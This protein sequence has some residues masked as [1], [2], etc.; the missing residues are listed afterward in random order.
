MRFDIYEYTAQGGRDYNE[1]AVGHIT[2]GGHGIFAVADGLGGHSLGEVASACARDTLLE[3]WNADEKDRE[4]W[5]SKII[6][7]AN[8]N[9]LAIQREK[10]KILKSTLVALAIDGEEAVWAHVGDSRLYFL[11]ED[12]IVHITEDHSVAYKKYKAGEITR[13]QIAT[14]EDQ[15][16]LL[17]TLGSEDRCRPK[18]RKWEDRL[19]PG[20]AF[21]LCSDGVWEYVRDTEVLIELLKSETAKE[22]AER[23]LMRL[24]GR[25]GGENDNLTL[26]TLMIR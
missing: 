9:I 15:S 18:I 14:D 13:S 12:E 4:A 3:G 1:D 17:R 21:L 25:I 26:L 10:E 6:T 5:F 24:M 22:W 19:C 7:T 16:S 11:H 8:E 23:L 2:D 20:D